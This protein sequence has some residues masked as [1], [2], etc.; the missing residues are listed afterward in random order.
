[1]NLYFRWIYPSCILKWTLRPFTSR[2]C[3]EINFSQVYGC[4]WCSVGWN[5]GWDLY[6]TDNVAWTAADLLFTEVYC[7]LIGWLLFPSQIAKNTMHRITHW[8]RGP[9]RLRWWDATVEFGNYNGKSAC[10]GTG[11]RDCSWDSQ[12]WQAS[13][14][15]N[16]GKLFKSRRI[17]LFPGTRDACIC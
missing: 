9:T 15:W 3:W 8:N 4:C 11:S 17:S 2:K 14:I 13:S 16:T 7:I 6:L 10:H 12:L 1:M 5:S